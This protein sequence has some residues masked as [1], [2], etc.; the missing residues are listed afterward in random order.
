M[1]WREIQKGWK[2]RN[3][4]EA[5]GFPQSSW[6]RPP[7]EGDFG[8]ETGREL[9]KKPVDVQTEPSGRGVGNMIGMFRDQ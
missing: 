2:S 6:G 9:G 1:L 7:S 4:S 3:S 8:R 5:T